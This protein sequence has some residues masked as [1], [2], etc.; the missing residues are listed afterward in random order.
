MTFFRQKFG[1]FSTFVDG[2]YNKLIRDS[3]YQN[4]EV[5]DWATHLKHLQ[6]IF[7]EFNIKRARNEDVLICHF[8]KG[9]KPSI[10]GQIEQLNKQLN[11]EMY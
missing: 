8:W 6:F 10:Y 5:W 3:Q 4:E 11:P 7:L 9:L 1:N 2:I